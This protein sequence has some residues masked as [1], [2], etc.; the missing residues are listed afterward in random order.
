MKR[1]LDNCKLVK[2]YGKPNQYDGVCE[3]FGKSDSDDEPCNTCQ[4]CKLNYLYD[5]EVRFW[6]NEAKGC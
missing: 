4:D 3:G 6:Q 5:D 2:K 1:T